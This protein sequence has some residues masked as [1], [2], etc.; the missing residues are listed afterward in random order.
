MTKKLLAA[1]TGSL[2]LI[3]PA[4]GGGGGGD[5]G[6]GGDG[7]GT[8]PQ[9]AGPA[10]EVAACLGKERID[11]RV[12]KAG[13]TL[14]RAPNARDAVVARLGSNTAN[15]LF[16]RSAEAAGKAKARVRNQDLA[17]IEKDIL[18]VF[19]RPPRGSQN[20]QVKD[21]L[22]GEQKDKDQKK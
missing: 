18:I 5:G 6:D 22:P 4:C 13:A 12:D 20:D 19:Q 14:V 10:G 15:V 17:N 7:G 8:P 21:C 3:A 9:P 11:A 16:F 2:L 1:M